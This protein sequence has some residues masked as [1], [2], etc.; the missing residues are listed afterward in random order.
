M[1]VDKHAPNGIGVAEYIN[2]RV[3]YGRAHAESIA[4]AFESGGKPG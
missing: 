1:V 4:V 2:L 3:G